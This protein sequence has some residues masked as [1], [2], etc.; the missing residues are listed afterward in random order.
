MQGVFLAIVDET[1]AGTLGVIS[2]NHVRVMQLAKFPLAL[3]IF[4]APLLE[5]IELYV[6]SG[7][8]LQ[9]LQLAVSVS[10]S[11]V[12]LLAPMA[13]S[14]VVSSG[15][16]HTPLSLAGPLILA[17]LFTAVIDVHVDKLAL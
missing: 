9:G 7:G 2:L 3:K 8:L 1:M 11:S 16:G 5:S 17:G 10:W 14:M 4:A 12:L 13:M 15:T 6:G